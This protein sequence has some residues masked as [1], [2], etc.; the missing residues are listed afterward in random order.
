MMS[1][2]LNFR[3]GLILIPMGL[4]NEY[5]ESPTFLSVN[6]PVSEKKIIPSTWRENGGGVYGT[7]GDLDIEPLL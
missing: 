4:V 2:A 3:A 6:R 1:D 7:I 5:H